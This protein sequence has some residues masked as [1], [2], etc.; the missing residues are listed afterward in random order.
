MAGQTF[1]NRVTDITNQAFLPSVIDS[2]N[3]S[4]VVTARFMSKPKTWN[5]QILKQPIQ[6]ANTTNGGSFNGF[7]TFDTSAQNVTD[8]LSYT[9]TAFYQSVVIS[10]IELG[11]NQT[12][13]QVVSLMKTAMEQAKNAA[14]NSIG[15]ILYGTGTGKDFD[16]LQLIVDDGTLTT[17]YGG[18]TRTTRPAINAGYNVA[19]TSGLLT[20]DL[21]ASLIDGASAAS[22][23]Q[24]S[25]S[26]LLTTKAVFSLYESLNTPTISNTYMQTEMAVTSDTS[27]GVAVPTSSIQGNK[28][29]NGFRALVWRGI[30]MVADDK[31]PTGILYGLNENYFDFY[32]LNIPQ[33]TPITL[34]NDVTEG[35]YSEVNRIKTSFQY[36][37]LMMPTNQLAEV[38]QIIAAGNLICRQPRRNGKLTAI[39]GV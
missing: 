8:V 35:V 14:A 20:L 7:D 15:T 37:D 21:L 25:P 11:V 5:G 26:L 17:T 38:G 6:Y 24:E 10:G 31:C 16:G 29:K 4:N 9:P 39:T 2:V 32:S 19:A 36:K 13:A 23:V 34:G 30:P 22:S 12:D 33:L 3:N 18:L 27:V 1:S 28:A